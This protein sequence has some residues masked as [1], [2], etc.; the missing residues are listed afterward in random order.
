M[1]NLIS[2]VAFALA[3]IWNKITANENA[4]VVANTRLKA[5]VL[6]VAQRASGASIVCDFTANQSLQ[7][8]EALILA[9]PMYKYSQDATQYV[10]LPQNALEVEVAIFGTSLSDI[11]KIDLDD[12]IIVTVTNG[13]IVK[14]EQ[15]LDGV[16]E[17]IKA[18]ILDIPKEEELTYEQIKAQM[19]QEAPALGALFAV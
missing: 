2:I 9:H 17:K 18:V 4:A 15:D 1:K 5:E 11:A 13:S 16:S 14:A 8:I 10:L 6:S 3:A 19:I 12:K 7:D